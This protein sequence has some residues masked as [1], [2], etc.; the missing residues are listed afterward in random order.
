M[1]KQ[2][3]K[4]SMVKR[5]LLV[6]MNAP[7]KQ[8]SLRENK[9][10]HN[11]NLEGAI[12]MGLK[13]QNCGVHVLCAPYG[14]GKTTS[15]RRIAN[16]LRTNEDLSGVIIEP[17]DDSVRNSDSLMDWLKLRWNIDSSKVKNTKLSGLIDE[18]D[19][20]MAIILDQFDYAMG[21]KNIEE[22]ISSMA[23][24]SVFGKHYTVLLCVK[25]PI[26]SKEIVSWNGGAKIQSISHN[27]PLFKWNSEMVSNLHENFKKN[28]DDRYNEK[29]INTSTTAGTPQFYLN[30]YDL[31][32]GYKDRTELLENKADVESKYWGITP[33]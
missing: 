7:I 33:Y 22:S 2:M 11:N 19:K 26:F 21:M 4:V 29:L 31:R 18:Q 23:E 6:K 9:Y 28:C 13:S 16:E 20:P 14:I 5:S 32:E 3:P 27:M 12:K 17:L 8:V 30:A 25:E 1:I 15:V 24:D 10:I